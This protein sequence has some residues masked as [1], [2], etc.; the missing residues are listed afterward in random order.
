MLVHVLL[1]M[2]VM[3][4]NISKGEDAEVWRKVHL[5]ASFPSRPLVVLPFLVADSPDMDFFFFEVVSH[6]IAQAPG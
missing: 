3:L 6:Y 2:C 5:Q 4:V 1:I